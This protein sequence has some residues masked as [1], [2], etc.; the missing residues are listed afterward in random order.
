MILASFNR[1]MKFYHSLFYG[2][3]LM[4]ILEHI[5]NKYNSK[6][7]MNKNFFIITGAMGSGKSTIIRAL[8]KQGFHVVDE[9]ARQILA[10]QRL[11]QGHGVPEKNPQL[12]TELM[13]SRSLYFYSKHQSTTGPVFFDRGVPDMMAYASLF[14]LGL[15]SV[16][17]AAKTCCYNKTVFIT[18]DWEEI[19]TTD[20]E[21][22]MSYE[23]AKAFGQ[24][25]RTIYQDLGYRLVKIPKMDI[26]QRADF[27][28]SEVNN[29]NADQ[30]L[31]PN[32]KS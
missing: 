26:V 17:R 3:S 6:M 29:V 1:D 19:Y 7:V 24:S 21:R 8:H 18:A 25:L 15:R 30:M 16:K 9:P 2:Q 22:T 23:Q 14:D 11:F 32:R 12:F 5:E 4:K 13:L 10:E 20:E 31:L 27:I 28:I